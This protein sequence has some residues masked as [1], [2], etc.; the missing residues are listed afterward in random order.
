MTAKKFITNFLGFS[1]TAGI[2]KRQVTSIVDTVM[3]LDGSASIPYCDFSK[4]KEALK[5][6]IETL[7]NPKSDSKFAAVTFSTTATVN[8]KFLPYTL[9]AS[10]I[11]RIPYSGGS[12]NTQAGLAEAKNLFDDP[13]SGTLFISMRAVNT[14]ACIVQ[15]LIQ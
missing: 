4:A 8:F 7:N 15:S 13:N 1:R 14:Y 9:A 11:M 12:T 6:V 10:E 5:H 2:T 3:V